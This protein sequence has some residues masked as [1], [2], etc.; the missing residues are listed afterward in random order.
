M[1]QGVARGVTY[2]TRGGLRER[3]A[4]PAGFSLFLIGVFTRSPASH[5]GCSCL[6]G[7][8]SQGAEKRRLESA[9]RKEGLKVKK[10]SRRLEEEMSV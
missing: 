6:F 3:S 1:M 2:V 10:S 4:C 7:T 9:R 5:R 8:S